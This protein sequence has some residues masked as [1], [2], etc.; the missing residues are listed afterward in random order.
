MLKYKFAIISLG[1]LY[2]RLSIFVAVGLIYYIIMLARYFNAT[3]I[4]RFRETA[5]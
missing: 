1:A 2:Y 3:Y 5:L 4:E